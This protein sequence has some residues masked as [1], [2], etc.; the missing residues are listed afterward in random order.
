S[1]A[2]S[3][4]PV[5]SKVMQSFPALFSSFSKQPLAGSAPPSNLSWT[6]VTHPPALGSVGLPGV[7]AN[8]SHLSNPAAFLDMHLVLL[9]MHFA[10]CADPGAAQTNTSPITSTVRIERVI[11]TRRVFDMA[12]LPSGDGLLNL[13]QTVAE[14]D[15]R[16]Q[17]NYRPFDPAG[18]TLR[19]VRH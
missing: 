15:R 13:A 8:P 18:E 16:C 11:P 7:S 3:A 6:L 4:E 9:A 1:T 5:L 14:I 12:A 19:H 10:C 2:V 17:V